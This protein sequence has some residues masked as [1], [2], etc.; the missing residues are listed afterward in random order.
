MLDRMMVKVRVEKICNCR[1]MHAYA[2]KVDGRKVNIPKIST[3]NNYSRQFEFTVEDMF[4]HE[5]AVLDAL[6]MKIL[7]YTPSYFIEYWLD[8]GAAFEDDKLD[9]GKLHKHTDHYVK[10]YSEF[11]SE[12][13]QQELSFRKY[14]ESP[15]GAACL[16]CSRK[17]QAISLMEG[18]IARQHDVFGRNYCRLR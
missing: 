3:I 11:F 8:Q 14:K 15:M 9:N 16:Y 5:V 10:R 12:L 17:A 6:D 18:R 13:S 4:R 1:C 2:M 7:T